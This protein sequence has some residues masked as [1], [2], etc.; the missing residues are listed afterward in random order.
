MHLLIAACLAYIFLLLVG[1][2]A[3]NSELMVQ[4]IAKAGVTGACVP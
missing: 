1:L 4:Y 3:T 2:Q